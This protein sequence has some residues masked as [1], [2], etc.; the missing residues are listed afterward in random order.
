MIG[1]VAPRPTPVRF[2]AS[3]GIRAVP[4]EQLPWETVDAWLASSRNYWL[5]TSRPDGRPHAKPVW[6]I[7]LEDRLL[8][9]TSPQSVTARNL[10][11]NPALIAHVESGD[12]TAILEGE[13]G[14]ER[15][16]DLLARFVAAYADKY[17]HKLELDEAFGLRPRTCLAWTEVDYPGTATR[18]VF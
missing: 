4:G 6:G 11:A 1:V 13:F 2:D 12:E 10:A 16:P 7:W 8:W 15:D 18:W 3:Y 17:D 14:F 5:C 9:G